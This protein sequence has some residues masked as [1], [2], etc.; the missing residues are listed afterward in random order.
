MDININIRGEIH[1]PEIAMLCKLHAAPASDAVPATPV[2]APATAAPKSATAPVAPTSAP[3]MSPGTVAAGPMPAP[4]N[5]APVVPTGAPVYTI[6]D[7]A[8]AG[9][10]LAQQGPD[11]LTALNGLLQQF[12]LRSVTDL[13]PDQMGAFVTAMRGLGAQ[14]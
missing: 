14:I 1:L 10:M 4:T 2:P 8:R 9:A 5:P 13:K 12:S 6:D 11:K 7:I 3:V